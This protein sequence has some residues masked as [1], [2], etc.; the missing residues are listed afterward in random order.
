[1]G[2]GDAQLLPILQEYGSVPLVASPAD[3]S[4][5]DACPRKM[6]QSKLGVEYKQSAGLAAARPLS[7]L[8]RSLPQGR[9]LATI[10]ET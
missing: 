7:Q 8:I 1:M 3:P 5:T 4:S 6:H 2:R 9:L 10:L